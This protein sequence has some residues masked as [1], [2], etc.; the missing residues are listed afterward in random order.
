[1]GTRTELIP[2][3]SLQCNGNLGISI[4]FWFRDR[5]LIKDKPKGND[6]PS[7]HMIDNTGKKWVEN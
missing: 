3:S 4:Y 7:L 5:M 1:M 2:T 6:I